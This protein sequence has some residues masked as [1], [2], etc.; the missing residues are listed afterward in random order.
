MLQNLCLPGS[1]L[2]C[3]AMV[4]RRN[5]C[6]ACYKELPILTHNCLRCANLLTT[7]PAI[8]GKCLSQPPPFTRTLTLFPYEAPIPLFIKMLKYRESFPYCKLFSDLFIQQIA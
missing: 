5:L 1:C 8:C 4:L 6:T 7:G 2:A 3:G